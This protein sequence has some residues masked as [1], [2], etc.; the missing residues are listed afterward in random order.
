MNITTCP[1]CGLIAEVVER[2]VLPSTDGPIEHLKMVCAAGH[3][4]TPTIETLANGSP[5]HP[6]EETPTRRRSP[7]IA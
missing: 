7:F 2:F 5:G 4:F 1:D 3:W 6:K